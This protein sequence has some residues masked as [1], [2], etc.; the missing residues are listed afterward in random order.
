M[1]RLV[2][3][4]VKNASVSIDGKLHAQIGLGLLI[5]VGIGKEDTKEDADWLSAKCLQMRIFSDP[6][7]KMNESIQDKQGSILAI[8]Q[9]TLYASTRKGNR[10]GFTHAAAPDR[11]MEM[12]DYF[13]EQLKAGGVGVQKGIFGADMQVALLNDGPVTI[14]MDSKLKE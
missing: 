10:P 14:I 3:Q 13:C 4:R 1:M 9:F 8:S 2:I 6:D 5:L 7:G 11:G 12:Y